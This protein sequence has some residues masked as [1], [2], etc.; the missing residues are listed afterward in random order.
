VCIIVLVQMARK[1]GAYEWG[2]ADD[3]VEVKMQVSPRVSFAVPSQNL[4]DETGQ[5][6]VALYPEPES[7][8][9]RVALPRTC[10]VGC[11]RSH[12][13]LRLTQAQAANVIAALAQQAATATADGLDGDVI[14]PQLVPQMDQHQFAT[15]SSNSSSSTSKPVTR[16]QVKDRSQVRDMKDSHAYACKSK[17]LQR[18]RTQSPK[19]AS[20][21]VSGVAPKRAKKS[22][23]AP[24]DAESW[25]MFTPS[26]VDATKCMAR[27]WGDGEGLQ[28]SRGPNDGSEYCG[29]HIKGDAWKAH[30]RIDG[31]IPSA[32]LKQFR[33]ARELKRDATAVKVEPVC[34]ADSAVKRKVGIG[35]DLADLASIEERVAAAHGQRRREASPAPKRHIDV[36]SGVGPPPRHK[37][38]A[39]EC[40]S[41]PRTRGSGKSKAKAKAKTKTENKREPPRRVFK[42]VVSGQHPDG[43]EQQELEAKKGKGRPQNLDKLSVNHLDKLQE[44]LDVLT[45]EQSNRILKLLQQDMKLSVNDE[46][47]ECQLDVDKMP[48]KTQQYFFKLVDAE[49]RQVMKSKR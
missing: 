19:R 45:G 11:S 35:A 22:A 14:V 46:K 43:E 6:S 44:K 39:V 2:H 9:F 28:C 48:A 30:G 23:D 7:S 38:A 15:A 18:S 40:G 34:D 12:G 5:I 41:P 24:V 10:F 1:L 47:G 32:K 21:T 4:K 3:A 17:K 27:V 20:E 31:P 16:S 42:S 49:Y 29:K 26:Q 36:P 13:Q 25:R 37:I 33:S 8:E